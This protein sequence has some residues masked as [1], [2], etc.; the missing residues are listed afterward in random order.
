MI[1]SD[2]P[3]I[4][5]LIPTRNGGRTL[6]EVF[7][8][9]SI[10][11]VEIKEVIVID[12]ASEDDSVNIAKSHGAEIVSI[13]PRT[14][15]HGGTRTTLCNL[16]QGEILVFLTQDAILKKRNSI[17]KL[18][19]PI[20]QD[21]SV[22]ACYGRQLPSHDANHFAESLRDFNYPETSAVYSYDDRKRVGI[23]AVFTS[24]SFACYR[25]SALAEVGYFQDGLIFGEDTVAVGR[26]LRRKYK[27]AYA[28][29]ALVYHSHNNKIAEDF[30]RYFDIGV[31][32]TQEKWLLEEYGNTSGQGKRYV[33][34]EL[35]GIL[36]K[37]RY[38]LLPELF[39]RVAMKYCGYRIGRYYRI[40]PMKIITSCTL[41]AR[42]WHNK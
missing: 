38:M 35:K 8:T 1:N 18:V 26:L 31:L 32:H 11:S 22:A 33:V 30:K 13:D 29:D 12:S 34:H 9:L 2:S 10:Q 7:A 42:W 4:S 36:K 28:A 14:F 15:D 19:T 39:A 25:K 40:L 24:N 6:A 41:N 23:K 16:A 37:R 5:V 3:S 21:T 20:L 27:N 17:E